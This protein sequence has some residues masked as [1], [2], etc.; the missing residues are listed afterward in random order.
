MKQRQLLARR[1]AP[2]V[3]LAGGIT[4][5]CSGADLLHHY[6]HNRLCGLR[7]MRHLPET[8]LE[9]WWREP[10]YQQQC[11]ALAH[12][13]EAVAATVPGPSGCRFAAAHSATLASRAALWLCGSV[14]P[15][16]LG[17]ASQGR[18]KQQE[19]QQ[20]EAQQQK[21]QVQQQVQ[22]RPLSST[23]PFGCDCLASAGLQ[24]RRCPIWRVLKGPC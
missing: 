11:G 12:W 20:K 19:V 7:G 14:Q 4:T 13:A 10:Q 17:P 5:G 1:A 2:D 3:R 21:Q 15:M 8:P 6:V 16:V 18:C 23:I 22:Q 9:G 24:A